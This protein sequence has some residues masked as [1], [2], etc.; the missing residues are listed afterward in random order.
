MRRYTIGQLAD[1]VGLNIETVRFYERRGLIPKPPRNE[2][3]YRQ[4]P[5]ETVEQIKFIKN[6]KELGFTLREVSELLSLRVT[7]DSSCADVR[8]KAEKKIG[9]IEEKIDTL[10]RIKTVLKR[11]TAA[12]KTGAAD[13]ECHFLKEL[14]KDSRR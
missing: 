6:A 11:L 14:V 5:K 4:F 1:E 3:G 8:L 9:E 12:C 10:T 7:H 13:G 2:S